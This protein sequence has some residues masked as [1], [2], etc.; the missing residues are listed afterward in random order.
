MLL[1]I[2]RYNKSTPVGELLIL[3]KAKT[4]LW[5]QTVQ[6]PLRLNSQNESL[7]HFLVTLGNASVNF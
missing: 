6:S 1:C 2:S 4:S 3:E 5:K 7:P